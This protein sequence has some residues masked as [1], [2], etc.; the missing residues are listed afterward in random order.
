MNPESNL[1]QESGAE[2]RVHQQL[3]FD[4][5]K[6]GEEAAIA[7]KEEKIRAR[8]RQLHEKEGWMMS[9]AMTVA[10]QES[11]GR[12]M[13]EKEERSGADGKSH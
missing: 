11:K 3:D 5:E 4:F 7:D 9:Y 2:P 1:P 8:A 12:E 6:A 13:R 10:R